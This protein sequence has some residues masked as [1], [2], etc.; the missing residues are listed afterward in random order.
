MP[1]LMSSLGKSIRHAVTPPSTNYNLNQLRVNPY[2][3]VVPDGI[4]LDLG[5]G[6]TAGGYAFARGA[7]ATKQS[8]RVIALDLE[9]SAGVAVRG[10]A[11]RIPL[12][13]ESV[14]CVICVSVL[15]YLRDPFLTLREIRRVL[16][17][18]GLVYLNAPF[19][20]PYHPPPPDLFRFSMAGLRVLAEGFEEIRV[21]YNRGPAST[22]CHILVHFV[23]LCGSFN[24]QQAYGFL[25][26]GARWMFF[27]VKYVDKWIGHWHAAPV[28]HSGAFFLG[29][30]RTEERAPGS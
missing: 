23:A 12:K 17:P 4:V 5:A 16:K 19:V 10:D 22:F 18:G 28:L 25:L 20:F 13:S 1:S 24:S 21:G 6:S 9:A 14:D 15:E 11:H 27:W 29:R 7:G 8:L 2:D 3:L 30:K 26:D